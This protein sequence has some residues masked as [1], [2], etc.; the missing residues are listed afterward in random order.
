MI[1]IQRWGRAATSARSLPD[2]TTVTSREEISTCAAP[3]R[4]TTLC[5]QAPTAEHASNVLGIRGI[6]VEARHGGDA[7]DAGAASPLEL[8]Q[9]GAAPPGGREHAARRRR[10]ARGAA[11][12]Q[13]A[14][15]PAGG[16]DRH[17]APQPG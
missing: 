5:W 17:A 16:P 13:G 12:L 7:R 9:A 8:F 2:A 1:R 4:S 6:G 14:R 15:A 3:L 11:A 10:E